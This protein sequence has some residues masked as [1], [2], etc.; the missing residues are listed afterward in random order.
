MTSN[1]RLPRSLRRLAAWQLGALSLLLSSALV[2]A[3]SAARAAALPPPASLAQVPQ[4]MQ[5]PPAPNVFITVDNSGSMLSEILPDP[6]AGTPPRMF[7]INALTPYDTSGNGRF[8]NTLTGTGGTGSAFVGFCHTI[9]VAQLRSSDFNLI[10]YNPRIRYQ[11]WSYADA[12]GAI[13]QYPEADPRNAYFNPVWSSMGGLDLTSDKIDLNNFQVLEDNLANGN[14]RFEPSTTCSAGRGDGQKGTFALYYVY[15][16]TR[17]NCSAANPTTDLNCYQRVNID[18]SGSY[19]IGTGNQRGNGEG[20]CTNNANGTTT[21]SGNAELQNFANW[22]VYYRSRT[23]LARGAMSNAVA[24]L[25]A[26]FRIGLGLLNGTDNPPGRNDGFKPPNK[27]NP[28]T[29]QLGVRDFTG[30][31]RKPWFDLLQNHRVNGSTPSGS[32]LMEVGEYFDWKDA[33]GAPAAAGPWSDD[34]GAQLAQF[35]SCRQSY[36]VYSTDGYWN[37]NRDT[38]FSGDALAAVDADSLMWPPAASPAICRDGITPAGQPTCYRYDPAATGAAS[39]ALFTQFGAPGPNNLGNPNNRR[40]PSPEKQSLADIAMYFWY[41]DLQ[42][43]MPNNIGGSAADPAFWQHLSTMAVA[44]GFTGTL[45][46]QGDAFLQALDNGTAANAW[47]TP[48]V[49]NGTDNK[50]ADDLW[51]AAVNSRGRLFIASNPAQLSSQL[52]AALNEIRARA[53][54]GAGAAS[55]TAFLDT[56]NGVFTAEIS[57]GTWSGNVY[58]REIDPA[59]LRFKTTDTAGNALPV[60]AN[61]VP[62]LWRASDRLVAPDVRPVFTM[63]SGGSPRDSL[64]EFRPNSGTIGVDGA[65]MGLLDAPGFG[66]PT[67]VINYLRGDRTKEQSATPPGSLRDRPRVKAGA[68]GTLNNVLGTIANS[69]PIYVQ[70]DDFNYDFLPAG[71][72]GQTSYL[73]FLRANQGSTTTTPRRATLWAGSNDG[74]FHAFDAATGD[75]LFAYVP[76]AV[77]QNLPQLVQPSYQHRFIVDG[78]P[79]FGDAYISPPGG[80]PVGWRTV[81]LSSLGAGGRAVFAIDGTDPSSLNANSVYWELG[82][83]SLAA[84][85]YAKLGSTLGA[86]FVARV[87]DTSATDGGRWVAV[88]ANG[89]E[90]DD[91]T[92]ALWIVDLQSGQPIRILD[93]GIGGINNPNGLSTPAPL[94]DTKRQLIAVYAGDLRGNV[95][96]FDLSGDTPATWNVAFSA[97]PLFITQSPG[98]IGPIA[99]Q[100]SPQPVFAKPLLRRHPD[101]GVMVIV[102]TGKLFAPGDRESEDVQSLYGVWDKPNETAGLGVAR[103]SNAM[104]Q[105]FIRAKDATKYYM[106][107]NLVGYA[108]GARGWFFDLGVVYGSATTLATPRER[109]VTPAI[110]LGQNLLVQS[111]VPSVDSCDLVGLSYLFRLQPLTGGFIGTGSFG[112]NDNSGAISMPGSFGLL[113]FIDRLAAGQDPST[114]TGVIFAIGLQGDLTGRRIDLGGL[115]TFRTWRQLLD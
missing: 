73:T 86:A 42:P 89:P 35:S 34:P 76:R 113:P 33:N 2:L 13:R 64:V 96:K 38:L 97:N 41:R 94:Y 110:A 101:G 11:P 99:S 60:D 74:M 69:S 43:A 105:Q 27:F 17:A 37:E 53:A 103:N 36:H 61:N 65:Q 31:N 23:L 26:G 25:G 57:Q 100:N 19:T 83:Q 4:F 10:Y 75:E 47:P 24:S 71:T 79:A 39:G 95:W 30:V 84:A 80:G 106:T 12:N 5:S 111:F 92:A 3:P 9:N 44:L 52:S 70:A 112:T 98:N 91:K 20:G 67:D 6:P 28:T 107:N 40:F 78:V 1:I 77:I 82:E 21:C 66:S 55:S 51:H 68:P 18:P 32:A 114:R 46:G 54:I 45:T 115:G 72:P 59:T 56:G 50:T 58:R 49:S 109:I 88:F 8:S 63:R 102:G 62:Y 14:S 104:V 7:P 15:D 108:G 90:S 85:D 29:V 16:T 81:V 48:F 93:T 22:F 87:K